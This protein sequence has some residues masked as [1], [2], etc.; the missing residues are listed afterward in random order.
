MPT[1]RPTVLFA[2]S[3]FFLVLSPSAYALRL[4]E[5]APG[6]AEKT[7]IEI[8]DAESLRKAYN[9]PASAGSITAMTA[10]R[11]GKNVAFLLTTPQNT[12][13]VYHNSQELLSGLPIT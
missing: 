13:S 12:Y 11:K 4:P 6:A 3:A 7:D 2:V 9:I 10:D 5:N 8:V 1:L